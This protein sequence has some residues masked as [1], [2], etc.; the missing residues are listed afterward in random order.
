[1]KGVG[2]MITTGTMRTFEGKEGRG[3]S[4]RGQ[5]QRGEGDGGDLALPPVS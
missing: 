1:M 2:D 4:I 5:G 3:Q